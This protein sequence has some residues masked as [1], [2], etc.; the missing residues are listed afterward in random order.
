MLRH[1]Q[2]NGK[3]TTYKLETQIDGWVYGQIGI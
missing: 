2:A 3:E 1:V